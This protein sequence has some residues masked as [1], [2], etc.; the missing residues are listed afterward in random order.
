[1]LSKFATVDAHS[2]CTTQVDGYIRTK[3]KRE[4]T[5]RINEGSDKRLSGPLCYPVAS[6]AIPLS[7]P[8][9]K[10]R[11]KKRSTAPSTLAELEEEINN[12]KCGCHNNK[13]GGCYKYNFYSDDGK[14]FL[15]DIM[16]RCLQHYRLKTI[17]KTREELDT[18]AL[19]VFKSH[20]LNLDKV[21][22]SNIDEEN[23]LYGKNETTQNAIPKHGID[24]IYN[25]DIVVTLWK[26]NLK[27][28]TLNL[29]KN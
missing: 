8:M 23:M 13:S 18:I 20:V 22:S 27:R 11:D 25:Y 21:I 7:K 17:N 5:W 1:M 29:R 28:M 24:F 12:F 19:G 16:K 15:N 2:E 10:S 3:K 14:D 6:K 26:K 4:R 9:Q